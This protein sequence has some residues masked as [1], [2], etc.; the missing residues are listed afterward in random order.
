MG[1]P[2]TLW[3]AVGM[4]PTSLEVPP[5]APNTSCVTDKRH[6]S[7]KEAWVSSEDRAQYSLCPDFPLSCGGPHHQDLQPSVAEGVCMPAATQ[8]LA[9]L[10]PLGPFQRAPPIWYSAWEP[11]KLSTSSPNFLHPQDSGRIPTLSLLSPEE[12]ASLAAY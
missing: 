1:L 2:E 10:R 12:T 5:D 3:S 9:S 11:L 8:W 6:Q 7:H 4:S